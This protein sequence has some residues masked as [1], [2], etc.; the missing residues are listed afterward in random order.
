MN[1]PDTTDIYFG[2]LINHPKSNNIGV[3]ISILIDREASKTAIIISY[4]NPCDEEA[5][6]SCVYEYAFDGAINGAMTGENIQFYV[7]S[8][9]DDYD[10]AVNG[11]ELVITGSGDVTYIQ[12]VMI[13]TIKMK[14]VHH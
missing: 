12:V 3:V 8:S 9:E 1:G 6:V 7:R 14:M 4:Y 10:V 2:Q 11:E 5:T 13:R